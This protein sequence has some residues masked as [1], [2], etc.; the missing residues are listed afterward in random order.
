VD[1]ISL[2]LVSEGTLK[3]DG[4]LPDPTDHKNRNRPTP[5]RGVAHRLPPCLPHILYWCR[6]PCP[7]APWGLAR[8]YPSLPRPLNP[9]RPLQGHFTSC[10]IRSLTLFDNRTFLWT[11]HATVPTDVSSHLG[12]SHLR[13]SH[14]CPPHFRPSQVMDVVTVWIRVE[15]TAAGHSLLL[16][17]A[18]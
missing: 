18:R 10:C 9:P 3:V 11:W 12:P 7:L 8:S 16:V 5:A 2:Q 13:S 17:L 1:K 15:I 14:I 4:R 6:G